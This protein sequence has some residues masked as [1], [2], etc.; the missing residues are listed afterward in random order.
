MADLVGFDDPLPLAHADD[1]RPLLR[2]VQPEG[3]MADGADLW[4][5]RSALGLMRRLHDYL[6]ARRGKAPG[7]WDVA[8]QIVV[9][10]ALEDHIGRTIDE[11]GRVRDDAS[12]MLLQLS[13]QLADREGRLRETLLA[14]LREAQRHG[15]ATESQPTV[16]GGRAVI[17]V[18]AEAKRKVQG[19]VHD[20]SATGQTVYIEPAAVLD[21][22]NEIRELMLERGREVERLLREV[23]AHVRHHRRDIE[24][25]LDALGRLDA[26]FAIGRLS[27]SLRALVPEVAADGPLRLV[28]ARHPVLVLHRL[29]EQAAAEA[30]AADREV[31]PLDLT[32]GEAAGAE[33]PVTTLV[34][35]G[36]N[37]GG[38][39]VA[40]KTVGLLSLMA[41][42]GLPVPAGPGTRIPLPTHLF[43]DLGDRQSVADD[44]S[45][46]TSHLVTLRRMLDEAGPRALCL[47]DEAGTGTDPAEGGALAQAVLDRLTRAGA[48]VIATTH[49]SGLKAYA[50]RTPSVQNGSMQFDRDSLAPT[51]RFQAG[52]PGSSY[53]FDIA[54]RVGLDAAL[55]RDARRLAGDGATRLEALVAEMEARVQAAEQ[56]QTEAE[57]LRDEAARVQA[58]YEQRLARLRAETDARRAAALAAADAILADANAAVE[59]AVREIREAGAEKEA[60]RAAR[61]QLDDTRERVRKQ[62]RAVAGRQRSRQPAPAPGAPAGP[63][64]VGDQ[65]RLDDTRS[66]GEIASLDGRE[67]VVVFGSLTS[68]VALGRL[69]KVGGPVPQRVEVRAPQRADAPRDAPAITQVQTRIDVRGARVEE[70]VPEVQRLVDDGLA[71]GLPSVEILHGKGTG[72]LRQAVHAHLAKRPDIAG[73]EAAPWNQ[74]GDGVTVVRLG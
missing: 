56:R 33:P 71:A 73:F 22:N 21:L 58:D 34:L 70:V 28:R 8:R 23:S 42:H 57:A 66:I 60:T 32:L 9:M 15:Y 36:P 72:A 39:S 25:S 50:H 53:A 17:P 65:V 3:A 49:H 64:A 61:A 1:L 19:F 67:A 45:T 12:P 54:A 30:P 13:R 40:M 37:A 11:S 46:F 41:A 20:V 16:R 48:T 7:L 4:S 59:R 5:A 62:T 27:V 18:R 14:A 44:L 52:V 31:I 69:T 24:T 10:K 51:Y 6:H 55:L 2:R 43:V 38:K 47:I 26:L 63:L 29:D 35:T 68:R 74:G